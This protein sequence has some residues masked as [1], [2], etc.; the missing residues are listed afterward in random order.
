MKINLLKIVLVLISIINTNIALAQEKVEWIMEPR[1]LKYEVADLHPYEIWSSGIFDALEYKP[2]KWAWKKSTGIYAFLKHTIPFQ[3]DEHLGLLSIDGKII[4]Q[5]VFTSLAYDAETG[6]IHAVNKEAHNI[7]VKQDNYQYVGNMGIV[8]VH[9]YAGEKTEHYTTNFT[10]N[11]CVLDDNGN[12]LQ[13]SKAIQQ[14]IQK[15]ESAFADQ[16]NDKEQGEV[17]YKNKDIVLIKKAENDYVLENNNGV[18]IYQAPKVIFCHGNYFWFRSKESEMIIDLQGKTLFRDFKSPWPWFAKDEVVTKYDVCEMSKDNKSYLI[19]K[20][21]H[22][23]QPFEEVYTIGSS[24][25][26][27]AKWDSKW[28]IVNAQGKVLYPNKFKERKEIYRKGFFSENFVSQLS[29]EERTT[30]F[31][32]NVLPYKIEN[33]GNVIDVKSGKILFC[34]EKNIYY[35]PLGAI[36]ATIDGISFSWLAK[37]QTTSLNAKITKYY[38]IAGT[39][40]IESDSLIYALDPKYEHTKKIGNCYEVWGTILDENLNVIYNNVYQTRKLSDNLFALKTKEGIEIINAKGQKITFLPEADDIVKK[41]SDIY[42]VLV[43]GKLGYC[44]FI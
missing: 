43:K 12:L 39:K 27:I 35:K 36:N 4:Q 24:D 23:S 21:G 1:Q 31:K 25:Q 41:Q 30:I 17:I 5:P 37:Y 28:G 9:K 40:V 11:D 20:Y 44:K 2:K 26:I 19:D 42:A 38:I 29:N 8:A 14:D 15:E 7:A 34:A 10:L 16:A 22:I 6:N 32:Q 18:V 33:G 13:D 3:K